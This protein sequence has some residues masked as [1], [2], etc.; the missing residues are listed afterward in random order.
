M[1]RKNAKVELIK[2][3]PLFTEC[4]RKDLNE[5]AGIA[6]EI[7]LREGKELTKEGR[8]GREFFVLIEGEADVKKGSRRVNTLGPGDFFGEIALVTQRPRTATVVTTAPVR[9]LVITDRSF[10]SLLEHQPA[11]QGKVMSAL[12]ARLGPDENL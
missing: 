12:A 1:L 5:I 2:G 3:V 6:D 8:P 11:I 7:D 10:R 4:S 9:A